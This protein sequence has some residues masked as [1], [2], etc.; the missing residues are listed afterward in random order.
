MLYASLVIT[1]YIVPPNPALVETL[2]KNLKMH[3]ELRGTQDM[4]KF[5]VCGPLLTRPGQV[6]NQFGVGR[7]PQIYKK[8]TSTGGENWG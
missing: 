6:S 7:G 8:W 1:K 3:F 4:L 5:F 2:E